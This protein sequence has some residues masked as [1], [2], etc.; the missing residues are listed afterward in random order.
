M[1]MKP[2][3]S[4]DLLNPCSAVLHVISISLMMLVM[5]LELTHSL[6]IRISAVR[7]IS[8]KTVQHTS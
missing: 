8:W 6:Q 2:R 7:L 4:Y 5:E 3:Q 1:R